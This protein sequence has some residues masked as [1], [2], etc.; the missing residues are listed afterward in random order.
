MPTA[1]TKGPNRTG[2]GT[3]LVGAERGSSGGRRR[4]IRLRSNLC[5]EGTNKGP[6][7]GAA[8]NHTRRTETTRRRGLSRKFRCEPLGTAVFSAR[9]LEAR[10]LEDV[11]L[12]YLERIELE[13]VHCLRQ[14][15][16]AG[17]DRGRP[18]RVQA[19]CLATF[20][21]RK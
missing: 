9:R 17:Y 13:G 3:C 8:I 14:D 21:E 11:V 7:P 10:A 19:L 15:H 1:S 5:L 6:F 12:R 16:A 20:I 18:V 4:C 2:R